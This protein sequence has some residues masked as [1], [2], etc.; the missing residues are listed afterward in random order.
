VIF[1]EIIV[2]SGLAALGVVIG[3]PVNRRIL[4]IGGPIAGQFNY[5]D[6]AHT[7]VSAYIGHGGLGT[8]WHGV[9]STGGQQNF[10]GA[11]GAYFK[12]LLRHFY[13]H[14]DVAERLGK[15]WL[16]VPWQPV[17]PKAEWSRLKAERG[18]RLVVIHDVVSRFVPGPLD[19]S[20]QTAASTYQGQR[21]WICAG[22]LHSPALLERSLNTRVARRFVS[23]HVLCYLGR[24]DRAR[25]EVSP[26][27]VQRTRDGLWFEGRYDDH[28]RALYT[29]RPARFAFKRLDR[30]IEQRTTYGRPTGNGIRNIVRSASL[31]LFAEAF[32]NRSGLFGNARVQSVYAQIDVPDAYE[33]RSADG[34]LAARSNVIRALVDDVRARPI[35]PEMQKS[36]RPDL[37]IPSIHLHHSIDVDKLEAAGVGGLTSRVQVVDASVLRNVGPDHHSFKMMAAGFE[38]A[39]HLLQLQ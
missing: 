37:F 30:G 6:Q 19:V 7:K 15:P 23:D 13:P 3:L 1:D 21:I 35:W 27:A 8:Y 9:I 10:V 5:Y 36:Q 34:G 20:V 14:T 28:A 22:A 31:G 32:Y 11:N 33:F 29:L 39:Q 25:A 4:V 18:D 12:Q 17:R 2:G 24:I 38:R 26:L 16:F